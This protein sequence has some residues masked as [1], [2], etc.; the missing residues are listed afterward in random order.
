MAPTHVL[1]SAVLALLLARLVAWDARAWWLALGFG[2]LID[3]DHLAHLP[4]F[5]ATQLPR[6]GLVAGVAPASFAEYNATHGFAG[7]FHSPFGM[8]VA[9]LVASFEQTAVPPL[10]LSLHRL[11]D[12]QI[13]PAGIAFAGPEEW[14]L[15]CAL[16]VAFALLA[17]AHVR[18]RWP[19][20]TVRTWLAS[21]LRFEYRSARRR[22]YSPGAADP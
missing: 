5:L 8:G 14:A 16:V 3:V 22:R 9:V 10:F 13:G 4:Q 18:A 11:M 7:G 12:A 20:L 1:A 21:P 6:H 2:A 17:H 19:Q 15:L